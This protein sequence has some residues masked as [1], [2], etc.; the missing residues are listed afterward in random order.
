MN[1]FSKISQATKCTAPSTGLSLQKALMIRAIRPGIFFKPSTTNLTTKQYTSTRRVAAEYKT[2]SKNS[3]HFSEGKSEDKWSRRNQSNTKPIQQTWNK[4]KYFWLYGT[5]LATQIVPNSQENKETDTNKDKVI[6]RVW[7]SKD[8]EGTRPKEYGHAS[9]QVFTKDCNRLYVSLYPVK[10]E[11]TAQAVLR[12]LEQDTSKR[13]P[14]E[15]I[16]IYSL[17]TEAIINEFKRLDKNYIKNG[18]MVWSVLHGSSPFWDEKTLNC[19]GMCFWLLKKGATKNNAA[20]NSLH[21]LNTVKTIRSY[22]SLVEDMSLAY[23]LGQW[24]PSDEEVGMFGIAI[25]V[26]SVLSVTSSARE[27]IV[28]LPSDIANVA[29]RISNIENEQDKTNKTETHRTPRP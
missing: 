14:D 12:T 2:F 7:Y 13:L 18:I 16:T 4:Y 26:A 29:K 11:N 8:V 22:G 24:K 5:L 21:E 9:L 27:D 15:I 28:L 6:V 17:D 10:P 3:S 25:M 1:L 19:A 20:S 23:V